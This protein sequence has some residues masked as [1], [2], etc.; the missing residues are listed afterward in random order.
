MGVRVFCG[1]T[2][3]EGNGGEGR[4]W[5]WGRWWRQGEGG[6]RVMGRGET[7]RRRRQQVSGKRNGLEICGKERN[8]REGLKLKWSAFKNS[9]CK[10]VFEMF[11]IL[12]KLSPL[13]K[14]IWFFDDRRKY[15]HKK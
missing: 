9:F 14:R 13:Y 8:G 11:I 4:M 5:R 2:G 3:G 15:C 1:S 10:I 12:T 6:E 7:R